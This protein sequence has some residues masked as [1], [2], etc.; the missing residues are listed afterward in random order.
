MSKQLQKWKVTVA[1]V[2]VNAVLAGFVVA[3]PTP[4][5]A[6]M[7]SYAR[8]CRCNIVDKRCD[9]VDIGCQQSAYNTCGSTGCPG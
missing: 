2:V 5:E 7:G 6:A 8:T 4:A 9:Y 1:L 3:R